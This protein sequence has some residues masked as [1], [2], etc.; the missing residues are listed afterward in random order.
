MPL[1]SRQ[2]AGSLPAPLP[3]RLR[4]K[5]RLK[6]P[7]SL[8]R[9]RKTPGASPP[10][11]RMGGEAPEPGKPQVETPEPS[12]GVAKLRGP[13]HPSFFL[14]SLSCALPHATRFK[15]LHLKIQV[16]TLSFQLSLR[17]L[18]KCLVT[19]RQ[20]LPSRLCHLFQPRR[21]RV[22]AS[23]CLKDP[24][25]IL[26]GSDGEC[27]CGRPASSLSAC[28]ASAFLRHRRSPLGICLVKAPN[29]LDEAHGTALAAAAIASARLAAGGQKATLRACEGRRPRDERLRQNLSLLR[30]SKSYFS[31]DFNGFQLISM[32]FNGFHEMSWISNG[33]K[34]VSRPLAWIIPCPKA[35]RALRFRARRPSTAVCLTHS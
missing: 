29:S 22:Q 30:A 25:F 8:R 10:A 35:R 21:S 7:D 12:T 16:L 3:Q 33:L 28:F 9:G 2:A 23:D 32:D 31:M 5:L 13:R 27:S 14:L 4:S 17:F 11:I 19:S 34:A 6:L 1:A 15:D 18:H 20:R 26:F 24:F